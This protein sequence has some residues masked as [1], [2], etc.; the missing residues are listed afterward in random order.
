MRVVVDENVSRGLVP[1][2][3]SLGHE[4]FVVG[5]DIPSGTEDDKVFGEALKRGAILITR[6]HHFTNPVRFDEGKTKGIIYV[7]HGNLTC[8]QEIKL[9]LDFFG[10]QLS[11]EPLEGK[12][13]TL[14]PDRF[15]IR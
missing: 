5:V 6:D 7:H 3:R 11:L 2:L 4:V 13:I 9:V 10:K 14:Y 8:E 15:N 12:L 1:P